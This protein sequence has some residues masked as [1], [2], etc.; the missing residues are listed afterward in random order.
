MTR[1]APEPLTLRIDGARC[2]SGLLLHPANACACF[3]FAHGAGAGM[4]H[5]FMVQLSVALAQR[6]IATIDLTNALGR[7]ARRSA[8]PGLTE[9]GGH[10]SPRGNAVVARA[11][12]ERLPRLTSAT[13]GAG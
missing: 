7:A 4:R 5:P 10:Y 9:P 8:P 6:G 3:V 1:S 2:V 13:C 11:L 12:A